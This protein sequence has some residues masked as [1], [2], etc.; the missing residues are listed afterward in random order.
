MM[1][2][3]GSNLYG[4]PHAKTCSAPARSSPPCSLRPT[5]FLCRVLSLP[6]LQAERFRLR[7]RH[8]Q[9]LRQ[10]E[11]LLCRPT[12]I[13]RSALESGSSFWVPSRPLH[14]AQLAAV[15]ACRRARH[16]AS[17]PLYR[18]TIPRWRATACRS[19]FLQ[20]SAAS[21]L[22]RTTSSEGEAGSPS[23]ETRM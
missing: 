6:V 11:G 9:N 17:S 8:S 20:Y 16:D 14:A 19:A 12:A 18:R 7:G 2:V 10:G 13:L 5:Q 4:T 21:A 1:G 15:R 3:K 23:P 22:P